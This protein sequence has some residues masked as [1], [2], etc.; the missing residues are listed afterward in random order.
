LQHLKDREIA[1]NIPTQS[2]AKWQ[3]SYVAR[4]YL[5]FENATLLATPSCLITCD[6]KFKQYTQLGRSGRFKDLVQDK[7]QADSYIKKTNPKWK[8]LWSSD[9]D[10]L[11][12]KTFHQLINR[13]RNTA[14]CVPNSKRLNTAKEYAGKG[15]NMP[16]AFDELTDIDLSEITT[17]MLTQSGDGMWE[18]AEI[19][20]FSIYKCLTILV[21]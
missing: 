12:T 1:E 16:V 20:T 13:N 10:H 17:I 21:I 7:K 3:K 15:Q 18:W 11:L 9:Q 4:Q 14:W 8:E 19:M 5:K 2:D 6:S